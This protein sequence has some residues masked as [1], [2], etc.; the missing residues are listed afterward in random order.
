[1]PLI[2]I[3]KT[4]QINAPINKVYDIVS[5]LAQW[6]AWSPWLIMDPNTEVNVV[7]RKSYSWEG[8]RTG[9]GNMQIVNE[10]QN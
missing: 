8:S 5:D 2:K 9:S 6:Q 1:M 4:K 7:D 10:K 3:V